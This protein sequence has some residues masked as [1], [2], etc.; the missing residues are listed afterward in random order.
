MLISSSVSVTLC[1][2][3][4]TQITLVTGQLLSCSTAP[5]PLLLIKSV[6][7]NKNVLPTVQNNQIIVGVGQN[8]SHLLGENIGPNSFLL[9]TVYNCWCSFN[10]NKNVL[11][12]WMSYIRT[13]SQFRVLDLISFLTGHFPQPILSL[14]WSD[15]HKIKRNIF[16]ILVC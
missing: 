6:G 11:Q 3:S 8:F 15:S 9:P 10:T 14:Y 12:F 13:M 16:M 1:F 5:F 4:S 7:P 2:S